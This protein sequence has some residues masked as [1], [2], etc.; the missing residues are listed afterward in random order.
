M[1]ADPQTR[2]PAP[3]F[4]RLSAGGQ[5]G[6]GGQMPAGWPRFA[7]PKLDKCSR[8]ISTC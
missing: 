4:C 7:T 1:Q 6:T 2:Q 8:L 3:H 5:Y